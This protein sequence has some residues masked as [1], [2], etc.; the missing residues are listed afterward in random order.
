MSLIKC[1]YQKELKKSFHL[2]C[3]YRGRES[4][5]WHSNNKNRKLDDHIFNL[6]QDTKR[7]RIG[8][9]TEL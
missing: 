1:H 8:S 2:V 3:V 9:G 6:T 7:A 4:S 5:C